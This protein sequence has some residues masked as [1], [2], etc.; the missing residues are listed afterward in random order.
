MEFDNYR[1]SHVNKKYKLDG[2]KFPNNKQKYKQKIKIFIDYLQ[3][4]A[5]SLLLVRIL[6]N[7]NCKNT[8]LYH[9]IFDILYIYKANGT[10][11][12]NVHSSRFA[13]RI[14]MGLSL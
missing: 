9:E 14:F 13:E 4:V 5:D 10:F 1:M 2:R 11:I 3:F 6:L 8:T 7:I 12:S